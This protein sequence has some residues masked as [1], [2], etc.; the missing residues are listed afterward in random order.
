MSRYT[1]VMCVIVAEA[2]NV[3]EKKKYLPIDLRYKKTRAIRRAL[4]THERTQKTLRQQKKD[5]NF[6]QRRF[7]LKA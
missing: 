5:Q 3:W 4:T 6:P 2:R 7:A 1:T